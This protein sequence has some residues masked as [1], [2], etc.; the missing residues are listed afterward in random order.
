MPPQTVFK[1]KF[2]SLSYGYEN[3]K[4]DTKHP[5]QK[6]EHSIHN[7]AF[8]KN[9]GKNLATQYLD[10][11]KISDFDHKRLHPKLIIK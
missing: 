3:I 1:I 8:R 11:E 2:N 4:R 9:T 10:Q 6:E 5:I 7:K